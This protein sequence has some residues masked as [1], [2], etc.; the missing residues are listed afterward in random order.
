[1]S[2]DN[3][4]DEVEQALTAMVR[5]PDPYPAHQAAYRQGFLAEARRLRAQQAVSAPRGLRLKRWTDILLRRKENNTMF[6]LAK[7]ALA[8]I[9]VTGLAAGTAYGADSSLP[10]QPLY[11]LDLELEQAQ[12]VLAPTAEDQAQLSLQIT[13][14]RA[15]ELI[16]MERQGHTPDQASLTRLS[17]QVENNL[18]ALALLSP[19]ALERLLAQLRTMA[20]ARASEMAGLGYGDGE[21]VMLRAEKEAQYGLDNPQG[22]QQRHRHGAGWQQDDTVQVSPPEPTATAPAATGTAA[23]T[24]DRQRDQDRDR[25][26]SCQSGTG[27]CEADQDRTRQQDR[28]Q[29]HAGTGN[30]PQFMPTPTALP[31]DETQGGDAGCGQCGTGQDG[32][33][34]QGGGQNGGGG[35]GDGQHRNGPGH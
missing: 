25:D 27:T 35:Q 6:T 13:S 9:V 11:P 29:I 1:M 10:G 22:F 26:G 21:Q 15:V 18:R 8:A 16:A 4:P 24:Q 19:E 28:D 14:E 12:M 2:D 34:S 23:P 7:A 3:V 30:G 32:G 17:A 31:S 5:I 33:S 20:Q